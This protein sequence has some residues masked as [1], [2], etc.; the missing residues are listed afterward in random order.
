MNSAFLPRFEP[1]ESKWS[2]VR[3]MLYFLVLSRGIPDLVRHQEKSRRGGI[4][5]AGLNLEF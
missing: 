1:R 5:N 3:T 4:S 2:N